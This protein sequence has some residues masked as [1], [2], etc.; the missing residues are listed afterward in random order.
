MRDSYPLYL[1]DASI[2]IFRAYFSVPDHFSAR[3]GESVNAVYGYTQFLLDLIERQPAYISVAF[4]E[5][6]VSCYRNE[7]YPAYKANRDLPD[8]NLKYQLAQ[9]Q[10]V[11]ELFGLHGL[12]LKDFE[13]DDIIG[14][15][16]K[17][18]D[19]PTLIITRDK[20]LGQLIGEQDRLW[21]FAND[22][23]SGPDD[24]K[25]K[26]GV[27]PYQIADFLALAGDAVDNIPGAPGIG[28]KTAVALLREFDTIDNLY[29]A[30]EQVSEMKLR[31]AKKVQQ[32]LM[33]HREDIALYR[34]IT[35]IECD[36]P[37]NT[38]LQDLTITPRSK[39]EINEFC[40]EM[41]FGQRIRDRVESLL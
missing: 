11:T 17:K 10:A 35:G 32:T 29:T 16:H 31:G 36:I 38:V 8:N 19:I 25:Q 20:D 24:V 23:L 5:S 1:V 34:Q 37:L 39:N 22:Q 27:R 3:N 15:L 9:C 30:I 12:S 2:Y 14:T 33:D 21:D 28:A 7:I 18:L 4:D 13:A 26:F 40:D 6:L 41:K